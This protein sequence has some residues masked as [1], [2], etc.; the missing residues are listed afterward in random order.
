MKIAKIFR[1]HA[2]ALLAL[3]TIVGFSAFKMTEAKQTTNWHQ[4]NTD[5]TINATPLTSPPS[6]SP[7]ADCST[8]KN[9]DM[10]AIQIVL[11]PGQSFPE[12]VDDAE[13]NNQVQGRAY[14]DQQ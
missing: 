1:K 13:S 8:A 11:Q 12:N 2:L 5:E 3:T 7:T 14:R 10:C 9:T 6:N 4:V